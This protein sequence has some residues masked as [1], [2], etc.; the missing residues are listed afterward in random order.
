MN[1][2]VLLRIENERMYEM[3]QFAI[4][5]LN[6]RF[7]DSIIIREQIFDLIRKRKSTI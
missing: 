5:F 3:L 4:E 2:F 7:Q 1:A 6:R